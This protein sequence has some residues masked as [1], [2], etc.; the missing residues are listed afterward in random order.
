[1]DPKNPMSI[2]AHLDPNLTLF[3]LLFSFFIAFLGFLFVLTKIHKQSFVSVTTSRKAIDFKRFFFAFSFWAIASILFVGID[4]YFSPQDYEVA[5][6]IKPFLI[7]FGIS[8]VLI[9]FQSGLEE[10]LFRG[11]LMQGF[12]KLTRNRWL[13]LILTSVIFGILHVFNP[14]IEKLGMGLLFYY[15]GTGFFFGIMTLMDEGIELALGFHIANN[16][17]TALLVTADWTAF[18]TYSVLKD[19]AEPTLLPELVLSLFILYPIS[20]FIL[21]KKYRW[22]NWKY[23]LTARIDES[24]AEL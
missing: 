6:Q 14:E 2:F 12:A 20:L 7:M 1:M 5:F 21:S 17:I 22:T 18:Q 8:V 13:P 19:I 16:L 4:Y 11:Y 9:P 15:I 3:L 23:K 24:K 10:Y